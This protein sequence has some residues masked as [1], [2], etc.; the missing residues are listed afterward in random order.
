M[1]LLGGETHGEPGPLTHPNVE[2]MRAALAGMT[3]GYRIP[4]MPFGERWRGRVWGGP[5][6]GWV[7]PV[8]QET[9]KVKRAGRLNHRRQARSW[10]KSF[11]GRVY[12]QRASRAML[13][14]IG[15]SLGV[16]YEE[17][18]G[19]YTRT[20]ALFGDFRDCE[21]DSAVMNAMMGAYIKMPSP[22]WPR[23]A[24]GA[25]R[26]WFSNRWYRARN[27]LSGAIYRLSRWLEEVADRI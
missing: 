3:T 18:T 4:I 26:R 15:G 24:R 9:R 11:S 7:D 13:R 10:S 1:N 25:V 21:L 16:S 20:S 2:R 12:S 22:P 19:E 17:M 8:R 23:R 27:R 14:M 6:R 5:G